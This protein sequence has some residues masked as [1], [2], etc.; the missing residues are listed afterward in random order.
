MNKKRKTLK[1]EPPRVAP[2]ELS[3]LELPGIGSNDNYEMALV[4]DCVIED[5]EANKATFD[6]VKFKNVLFSNTSLT[7]IELTDVIFEKCDLSNID[8]SGA[9]IHRTEFRD[10]KMMGMNLTDA[11]LRNVVLNHCLADYA[12]F[13]FSNMK[14]VIIQDS[15]LRKADFGYSKWLKVEFYQ[16]DIDQAQLSDIDLNGI[17]LSDCA[18][19]GLGVNVEN[20]RGCIITREQAY[21]FANL[22]GL[23]IKE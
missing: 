5:Q 8:F 14:Q 23:I 13:R 11:T 16:A 15:F 22:F 19:N 12:N 10:C 21:V 6:M 17:D 2:D 18:F 9:I 4:Q 1:I 20:L 7:G 3:L